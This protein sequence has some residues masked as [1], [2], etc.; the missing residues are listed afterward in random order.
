[1]HSKA[2]DMASLIYRMALSRKNNKNKQ[3]K[4]EKT[5]SL[6][7]MDRAIVREGSICICYCLF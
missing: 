4:L 3:K 2:E 7:E 6:E 1:M 5:S